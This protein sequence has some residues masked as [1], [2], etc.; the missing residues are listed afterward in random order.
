MKVFLPWIQY[1]LR[2][3]LTLLIEVLVVIIVL[4]TGIIT[5]MREREALEGELHKRGFSLASDLAKFM[6]RPLLEQDLSTLR[7]L[8]NHSMGQDY[9]RHAIVLDP[10]STVVMHSDL[11]EVGKRYKDSFCMAAGD[12]NES[13]SVIKHREGEGEPYFDISVPVK[14]SDVKLGTVCLGYSYTAVEK[15]I[16]RARNQIFFAGL[17]TVIIG[18]VVAYVLATFISSPIVRITNAMETVARGNLDTPIM[19]K[20]NDEVGTLAD[21]FN[22]MAQDLGRHRKRLEELVEERTAELEDTN[23][24][25]QREIAERKRS[26]K[27]LKLSHEMLRDLASHLQ[28]VREDERSRIAREIHD[29]L[30]QALTAIKMDVHWVGQRLSNDQELLFEKVKSITGLIDMTAQSVQRISSELRPGLLDDLGLSAAVEWQANEFE[31]RT[32]VQCTVLSDPEDIALDRTLS[33]SIFRIFQEALTNIARHADATEVMIDLKEKAGKVELTVRDNGKGITE[34]Q[35]S[36]ARSFGLIG[37]RERVYYYGGK[38]RISGVSNEGTTVS[39]TIPLDGKVNK[40]DKDHD[41][42]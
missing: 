19:I 37:M 5:T 6:E 3:K 18:G 26:E 1:S 10:D 15:E 12:S 13:G 8:V 32:G 41:S 29:E 17:A 38:L 21:S 20:R 42:G 34:E 40:N 25:L 11:T 9:V 35:I 2:A 24:Q 22:Q 30:G 7:R 23:E 28:F 16:A 36:N 31:N 33:T 14:I 39:L 27:K 4:G